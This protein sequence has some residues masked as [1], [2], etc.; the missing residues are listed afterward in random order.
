MWLDAGR[1]AKLHGTAPAPGER[2]GHWAVREAGCHL[3]RLWQL[4]QPAR[5]LW[6]W[7]RGQPAARPLS[8]ALGLRTAPR[9]HCQRGKENTHPLTSGVYLQ[10]GIANARVVALLDAFPLQIYLILSHKQI[11]TM[12]MIKC[13]HQTFRER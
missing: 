11:Q 4:Q 5:P 2:V 9:I 3:G 10:N 7:Q 8:P 13:R 1:G 12:S 6:Q